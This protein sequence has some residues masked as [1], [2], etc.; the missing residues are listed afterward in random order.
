M[1]LCGSVLHRLCVPNV[2][3]RAG[4][5]GGAGHAFPQGVLGTVTLIGVRVVLGELEPAQSVRPNLLS[6]PWLWLTSQSWGLLPSSWSGS[7]EG[8][9]Q[10]GSVPFKCVSCPSPHSGAPKE[11]SAEVSGDCALRGPG[12][13]LCWHLRLHSGAVQ[14]RVF[15]PV[16]VAPALV[17][18]SGVE[19]KHS[20]SWEWGSWRGGHWGSS[21]CAAVRGLAASVALF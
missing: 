8:Q 14:G 7:P 2:F 18:G 12:C 21:G 13:C 17:Q 15:S 4:Y 11:G 3:V 16:V 19:P 5:D 20:P 10:A 6:A 9:A 1:L